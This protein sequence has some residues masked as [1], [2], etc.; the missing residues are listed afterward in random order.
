MYVKIV[1]IALEKEGIDVRGMGVRTMRGML[2][3]AA[4]MEVKKAVERV[5]SVGKLR[6]LITEVKRCYSGTI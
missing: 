1:E 3:R 2:K 4:A 6:S 5:L